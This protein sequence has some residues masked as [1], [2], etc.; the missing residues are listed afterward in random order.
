MN[1]TTTYL[2]QKQNSTFMVNYLKKIKELEDE[3]KKTKYNKAT[4]GH[5]G[6]VKAKIAQLKEKQESRS[7]KKTGRSDYGYSVRKSGDGS[8]LLLGFPSAGKSTLLNALTGANSEVASYAFTT[9]SVVPGMMNYKQAKIQILDVPGIVSG[10]ASGK[11]RGREV[12]TVIHNANLVLMV[13]DVNHPNHHPAILKEVWESHIRMNKTKPEVYIKKKSKGGIQ[14][15]KTVPL[16]IDDE[17]IKK[18][19]R[20]FK[21]VNADILIRS[22]IDVDD[23]IDCIESNKKYLPAITCITKADLADASTLTKVKKELNADIIISA[24][25]NINIEPL[26]ELIF[27]KLNFIRIYLKEPRKEADLKEPLIIEK[28]SKIK[29]VCNKLH[30]DFAKRFK[31]SRVWGKSAKF[32]GQRLMLNHKLKDKDILEVHLD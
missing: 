11:G 29:D 22:P 24:E 30:R 10:A 14:I 9:L 4:Q 23:L 21:I 6:I 26:K 18:V 31:F 20:E 7:Q 3:L 16:E 12:L 25:Q 8:V 1:K 27:K 17:T 13:I 28:D 15:G 32:P 5:I 19:L 2:K